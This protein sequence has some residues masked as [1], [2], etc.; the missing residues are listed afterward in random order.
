MVI[1]MLIG[2]VNHASLIITSGNVR[3]ISDLWLEGRVFHEGWDLIA[4]SVMTF[5]DFKDI[6]H[7]W[8]SHEHPDHF[9]RQSQKNIAG[10][11]PLHRGL[12]PGDKRQKGGPL[13]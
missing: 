7:I 4:K 8:F 1:E 2:F 12:V 11:P 10:A 6:T 3:L 13:L 9:S 5:E